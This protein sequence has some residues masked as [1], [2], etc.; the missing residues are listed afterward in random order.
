MTSIPGH[1]ENDTSHLV[2]YLS[3]L[4]CHPRLFRHPHS[5]RVVISTFSGENCHFGKGCLDKGWS[6]LKQEL[7]IVSPVDLIP[8][9]FTDPVQN[10]CLESIDG[11]FNWNGCWPVYLTPSHPRREMH[12][13]TDFSY[14][15]HLKT[16]QCFMASVS[17]WFFTHYGPDTWNKN[18]IYRADDWLFVQRWE[19]LIEMRDS[20]NF[21]QVISWND[22]GESH[23]IGPIKGTQPDSQAWV[24]G[25]P[26]EAWLRLNS[27]FARA[28]KDGTYPEITRDVICVWA[29]PHPKD[30]IANE[31]VPRPDNWELTDDLMW[32]ILFTIAP[33]TIRIHTSDSKTDVRQVDVGKGMVKLSSPLK[34]GGGIKVIMLRN[35]VVVAECTPV[36]YRFEAR[37]GVYNFNVFVAMSEEALK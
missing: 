33:A 23:Y 27:F 18:W 32:I 8:A 1:S 12:L 21:V 29:R 30:A 3:P 28:F 5:G 10:S 31:E 24:D 7:S 6:H 20:I 4:A 2:S 9:F 36:G 37:P 25:Y 15:R 26:H 22:Y 14:L 11:F 13:K 17:P 16:G 34:V 19:Q 35:G